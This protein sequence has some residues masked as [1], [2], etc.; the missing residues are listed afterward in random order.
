M[1]TQVFNEFLL[2][3]V[4]VCLFLYYLSIFRFFPFAVLDSERGGALVITNRF[5]IQNRCIA[6]I[7]YL[8]L[9][10]SSVIRILGL[11]SSILVACTFVCLFITRYVFVHLR[12]KSVLRGFGAPGFMAYWLEVYMLLYVLLEYLGLNKG[13]SIALAT[14]DMS[15]IML[16]AGVYKLRSGYLI[17]RGMNFG[18]VNPMWSY[19]PSFFSAI[20]NSSFAYK[21]FNYSAVYTELFIGFSLLLSFITLTMP[22]VDLSIYFK[23]LGCLF[24]LLTFIILSST[25]RL[26]LLS[27]TMMSSSLFLLIEEH[28]ILNSLV[29]LEFS[30]L[31]IG[32]I[33]L[34]TSYFVIWSEYLGMPRRDKGNDLVNRMFNFPRNF[35]GAIIWSVFSANH[36]EIVIEEQ[37]KNGQIFQAS[38]NVHLNIMFT[39]LVTFRR[40]Y[41]GDREGFYLRLKIAMNFMKELRGLDSFVARFSFL[42]SVNGTEIEKWRMDLIEIWQLDDAGVHIDVLK[43]ENF[44][45]THGDGIFG[46]RRLKGPGS[47]RNA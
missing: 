7:I 24:L 40:Y 28:L 27:V 35:T 46:P 21:I 20:K 8:F 37:K 47:Y 16:S 22:S 14:L 34:V 45:N 32:I 6:R 42:R 2:T 5:S 18:L 38:K 44:W 19:F 41:P 29:S 30:I 9:L 11:S 17:G 31:T 13:I 39:T 10:I 25:V 33:L 12:Y 4:F 26:G 3:Q 1:F 36:T 15:L 23:F 43:S